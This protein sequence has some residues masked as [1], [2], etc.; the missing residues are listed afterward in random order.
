MALIFFLPEIAAFL[1]FILMA[2][3]IQDIGPFLVLIG[4][5]GSKYQ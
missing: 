3:Q 2:T 4:L 1:I 5:A